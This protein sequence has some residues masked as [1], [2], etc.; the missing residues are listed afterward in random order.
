[1]MSSATAALAN[2]TRA[3]WRLCLASAVRP[4]ALVDGALDPKLFSRQLLRSFELVL[5]LRLTP[6][7]GEEGEEAEICRQRAGHVVV[8]GRAGL[9]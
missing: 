8:V 1:M 5:F 9:K 3:S 6:A 2:R 7:A 4:F